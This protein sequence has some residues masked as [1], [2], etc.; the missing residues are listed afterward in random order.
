ML[1]L[2]V[3]PPWC[4]LYPEEAETFAPEAAPAKRVFF[5]V[6]I[7]KSRL[8]VFASSVAADKKERVPSDHASLL[9]S[10]LCDAEFAHSI[11]PRIPLD[12]IFVKFFSRVVFVVCGPSVTGI[13]RG[14]ALH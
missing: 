5:L 1:L 2:R 11:S 8:G 13:P 4:D 6:P 10:S 3:L 14:F 12:T 9:S 7:R